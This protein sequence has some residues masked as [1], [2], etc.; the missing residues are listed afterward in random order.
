MF[1]D[2]SIKNFELMV[3]GTSKSRVLIEDT[4]AY[5]LSLINGNYYELDLDFQELQDYNLFLKN[6][7]LFL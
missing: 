7:F 1:F 3:N 4:K 6:H 2:T 5:I